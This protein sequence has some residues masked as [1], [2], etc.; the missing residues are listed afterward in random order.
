MVAALPAYT[1]RLYNQFMPVLIQNLIVNATI[2]FAFVLRH[3]V[4]NIAVN[5]KEA[6]INHQ[7]P[8]QH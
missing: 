2:F 5:A 6:V 1:S 3:M 8:Q 7:L 4:I